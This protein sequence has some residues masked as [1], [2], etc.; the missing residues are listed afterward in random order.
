MLILFVF[1]GAVLAQINPVINGDFSNGANNQA[2]PGWSKSRF[3]G[4]TDDCLLPGASCELRIRTFEVVAG[5]PSPAARI[6][7]GRARLIQ[8]GLRGTNVFQNDVTVCPGSV[9]SANIASSS[10]VQVVGTVYQLLV[11]ADENSLAPQGSPTVLPDPNPSILGGVVRGTLSESFNGVLGNYSVGVR[12]ARPILVNRFVRDYFDNFEVTDPVPPTITCPSNIV[13]NNT[14]GLCSAEVSFEAT[15]EDNCGVVTVSY[16]QAPGTSFPVGTTEVVATARD[17]AGLETTCS[18]DV[19]VVDAESPVITCPS[20]IKQGNDAGQCGAVV[21]FEANATDNCPGVT[22]TYSQAPG[23]FFPVGKTDVTA[24]ATDGQGQT[25]SCSFK[26]VV[27]DTEKPVFS[28]CPNLIDVPTDTCRG[29]SVPSNSFEATDNCASAIFY[30]VANRLFNQTEFD[31]LVFPLGLENVKAIAVD[32]ARNKEV[33]RSAVEVRLC[34][35]AREAWP[36]GGHE[37]TEEEGQEA[38]Q[39]EEG[40]EKK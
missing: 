38:A 22:V 1:F 34:C 2:P 20:K 33:C 18:F 7:T 10:T 12:I 6:S 8:G 35:P 11:G 40:E 31:A 4:G 28:K 21:S 39:E 30:K 26:V 14:A 32:E 5:V 23:T 17:A 29:G 27:K 13:Q 36:P 15:A 37:A 25:S 16:S 24:T 19:T 9:I 3:N